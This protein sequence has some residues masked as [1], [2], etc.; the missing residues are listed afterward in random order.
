MSLPLYLAATSLPLLLAAAPPPSAAPT[1]PSSDLLPAYPLAKAAAAERL[2]DPSGPVET[3][4]PIARA[5]LISEGMPRFWKGSYR[6]FERSQAVPV[7]LRIETVAAEGQMVNLRGRMW[8]DGV[9]TAVQ[10]NLNA[11]SDQLDLLLL[12][13]PLGGDLEPGGEFQ[14]LQGLSLSGWL[15]PRL[16]SLGGRL[17]LTPQAAPPA[18]K[19]A[20]SGGT[21][22]GLW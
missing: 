9:A 8:I 13:H 19:G 7:E 18:E 4:D 5:Q 11:K 6:A 21:I 17:Q 20:S 16:T 22:R 3:F 10:G 2:A 15:A 1:A 14:G 12:D